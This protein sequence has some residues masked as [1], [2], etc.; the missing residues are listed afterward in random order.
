AVSRASLAFNGTEYLFAWT[1]RHDGTSRVYMASMTPGGAFAGARTITP[2][3]DNAIHPYYMGAFPNPQ[4]A[5]G[6]TRAL[7]A[8]LGRSSTGSDLLR[9]AILDT[10]LNGILAGPFDVI[11]QVLVTG[12]AHVGSSFAVAMQ[13]PDGNSVSIY[14]FDDTT[15]EQLGTVAFNNPFGG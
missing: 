1:D 12:A 14:R 13:S 7:I 2:D 4:L 8:W 6:P 5:L 11:G 10:H 15:G 9:Y 3:P